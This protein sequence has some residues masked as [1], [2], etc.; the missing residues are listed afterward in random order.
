MVDVKVNGGLT[1]DRAGVLAQA[2]E[3]ANQSRLKGGL[4]ET[5]AIQTEGGGRCCRAGQCEETSVSF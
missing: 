2:C 4:K 5:G 1:H 3:L